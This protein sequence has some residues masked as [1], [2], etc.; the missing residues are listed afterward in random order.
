[1]P[2]SRNI[3]KGKSKPPSRND[4]HF[5]SDALR[6]R[7]GVTTEAVLIDSVSV[8]NLQWESPPTSPQ[9]STN[10]REPITGPRKR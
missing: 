2:S 4:Q 10:K 5:V 1:M 3:G 6:K 9:P 8:D 7:L